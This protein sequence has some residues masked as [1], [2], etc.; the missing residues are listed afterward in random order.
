MSISSHLHRLVSGLLG[1]IACLLLTVAPLDSAR[2]VGDP[3]LDYRTITTPHFRVHY[4]ERW[5]DF[6]ERVA[7]VAEESHRILVPL[8]ANE[9]RMR[10]HVVVDDSID[11]ANGSASTLGRNTIN[12]LAQPP[13]PTSVLGYYDDWLRILVYHEYVH[14]LHLDTSGGPTSV[15]NWFLG[16]QL[17]PNAV[18]PRWYIEG[19]AVWHESARTG[20]GRTNSSL[21]RM[22]LRTAA[23]SDQFFSLG[24]VTGSPFRWPQGTTPYL[25][26]GFF[27]EYIAEKHGNDALTRFNHRYGDQL[28]PF[29]LN[30]LLESITGETFHE[31]WYEWGA[32]VQAESLARQVAIRAR[33]GTDLEYLTDGGGTRQDPVVRPGT[34]QIT[35][36]DSGLASH[37]RFVSTD[38]SAPGSPEEL[39]EIEGADG[40]S[41]WMPDGETLVYSRMAFQK[42]VYRY[43]DLYAWRPTTGT[44]RRLTN[45]E[46][47]RD[48]AISPDGEHVAYVR[49]ETGTSELVVCRLQFPSPTACRTLVEADGDDEG[50]WQQIADPTWR[51]D[52]GAIVF[53]WW[54]LDR[55]QRD[56]W[57][58]RLEASEEVTLEPVTRDAAQDV[59]PTFGP[60]GD[61]YFSSDRTGIY[62]IYAL[63]DETGR[64]WQVSDVV[65]GVFD[66]AV[67]PE[68][69]W[70]YVSA[71]TDDGYE[72]ARMR[73][74]TKRWDPAPASYEGAERRAYPEIETDDWERG[75][76]HP[77]R[78]MLPYRFE[79]NVGVL[80]SGSGV[81]GTLIGRGPVGRHRWTFSG[82]WLAGPAFADSRANVGAQYSFGGLPVDLSIGA[83]YRERPRT[84]SFVAESRFVPYVERAWGGRIRI[85][86]PFR[87][88]DDQ[89]SLSTSLSV[90][91]TSFRERPETTPEPADVTPR[92]PDHGWSYRA[93]FS[94]SYNNI[95]RFP[96][97]IS[98][99]KGYGGSL[100]VDLQ[101]DLAGDRPV[102]S[103]LFN[104]NFRGYYPNPL[105]RRHVFG[106]ELTGGLARANGT[107][108]RAYAIGGHRPRNVL[109]DILLQNPSGRFVVRGYEPGSLVG[110]QYQIWTASYRFPLLFLDKG[111]ST[112]PA[113]LGN[114][115]GDVFFDAGGAF[116]GLLSDAKLR[117]SAGAELLLGTRLGYYFAGQLR[118]GF[119][120]GFSEGGEDE[121]Y[122]LYGGGF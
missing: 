33:G 11:V 70:I 25:Y 53:S 10:T 6:A 43:H 75:D 51:P 77:G 21:F 19:L 3:S 89:L 94:L 1:A 59:A 14:I 38:V 73:R 22:W 69:R 101:R 109:N 8:L 92:F 102:E 23:L 110:N 56:L 16:N 42:N 83:N 86:Y 79:P 40:S 9:P 117:T 30:H 106:L 52:G 18:L 108:S 116:D 90:D 34:G 68:G 46:R 95:D 58:Y 104:Y 36:Y 80:T 49:T 15:L 72:I 48:P 99:E 64:V 100:G 4:A 37:A 41:D 121:F 27:M 31:L 66:P 111:F 119:A 55:R 103:L 96:Q 76:Y 61:L 63:D 114:L 118:L 93:G 24:T 44:T 35:Y 26:G 65:R 57:R 112:V 2:G 85:G 45:G 47:A 54:R 62:N 113:F 115:K 28:V 120:H 98:I 74:P 97:S 29:N 67:S 7:R 107:P 50:R 87:R 78:W 39:F 60:E 12:I 20:T 84:R 81:G 122:L 91:R 13:G 71:Y 32:H 5:R 105:W 17:H 88:I 82:A